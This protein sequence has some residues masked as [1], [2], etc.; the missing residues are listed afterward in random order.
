VGG[1]ENSSP[2][3]TVSVHDD[4]TNA[5]IEVAG[6]LDIYTAPALRHALLDL[7]AAGRFRIVVDLRDVVFLDSSALGVLV[8]GYK[9]ASTMGGHLRVVCPAGPLA[10]VFR[11]TGLDRVLPLYASVRD[12]V[13]N[14]AHTPST[15]VELA[16]TTAFL[17]HPP[18]QC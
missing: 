18:E 2:A 11:V 16:T 7:V 14:D 15:F 17:R 5:V 13:D 12:A 4:A 10:E 1:A 6:E 9:R 8:G 3:F